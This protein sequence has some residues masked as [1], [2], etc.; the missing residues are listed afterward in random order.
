MPVI[1]PAAANVALW[2]C[3]SVRDE[4]DTETGPCAALATVSAWVDVAVRP[5]WSVTVAR[6]LAAPAEAR[7]V[8]GLCVSVGL[9]GCAAVKTRVQVT[10]P[11]LEAST[12]TDSIG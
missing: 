5:T 1:P 9:A 4:G 12:T 6:K 7:E 3:V 10:P 8:V 11:S 2:P